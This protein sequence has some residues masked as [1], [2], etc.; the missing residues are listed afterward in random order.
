M[1]ATPLAVLLSHGLPEQVVIHMS[2]VFTQVEDAA[3]SLSHHKAGACDRMG[4]QP[5]PW[6]SHGP[7]ADDADAIAAAVN[8]WCAVGW[9]E[10]GLLATPAEPAQRDRRIAFGQDGSPRGAGQ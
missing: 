4:P 6:R 2:T 1:S 5:C 8:A 10:R 3:T 7:L 9:L